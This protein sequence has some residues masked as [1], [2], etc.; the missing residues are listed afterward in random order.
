[1]NTIRELQE[2]NL[3]AIIED[4]EYDMRKLKILDVA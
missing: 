2:H 4:G 3:M 1:V